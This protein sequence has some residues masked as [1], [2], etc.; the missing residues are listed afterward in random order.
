MVISRVSII[1]LKKS[2]YDSEHSSSLTSLMFVQRFLRQQRQNAFL[3]CEVRFHKLASAA[4]HVF[5]VGLGK[6]IP[7]PVS[8]FI[9]DVSQRPYAF[10]H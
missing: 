4:K 7:F 9:A 2:T 6:L 1:P 8:S 3:L 10:L 5:Y